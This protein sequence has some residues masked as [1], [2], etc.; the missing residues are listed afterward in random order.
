MEC[1]LHFY[2]CV[3][4]CIGHYNRAQFGSMNDGLPS[5]RTN[6]L[7]H[8]LTRLIGKPLDVIFRAALKLRVKGI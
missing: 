4:K 6:R 1:G 5:S 2:K 8:I 7:V 3:P